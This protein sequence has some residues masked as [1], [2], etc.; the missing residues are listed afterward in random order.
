VSLGRILVAW[1]AVSVWLYGW[2]WAE[3]RAGGR[4]RILRRQGME[5]AGEG[6]V[7]TLFGALWFGSLGAGAWWL[8]FLLVGALREW[9]PDS[10]RAALRALRVIGAGGLLAWVLPA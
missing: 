1:L 2:R 10:R 6:L 9:P 7:L 4:G 5:L 8:V 3:L